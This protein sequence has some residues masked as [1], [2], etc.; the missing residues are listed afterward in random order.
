MPISPESLSELLSR[1]VQRA[2]LLAEIKLVIYSEL[3]QK[4]IEVLPALYISLNQVLAETG[5]MPELELQ[6]I[7]Q[8]LG[9][10]KRSN[11]NTSNKKL[12]ALGSGTLET[13]RR[14]GGERY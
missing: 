4:L 7:K 10:S 14:Q 11:R 2:D 3:E 6:A 13:A 12:G 8:D 9:S 5:I 1:Q